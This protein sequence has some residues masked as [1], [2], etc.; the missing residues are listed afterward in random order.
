MIQQ[1]DIKIEL[2]HDQKNVLHALQNATTADNQEAPKHIHIHQKVN[3]KLQFKLSTDVRN[4]ATIW[5][6]KNTATDFLFHLKIAKEIL[7]SVEKTIKGE[8]G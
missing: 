6:V 5:T 2:A 3:D 4:A 7:E 1:L 8:K